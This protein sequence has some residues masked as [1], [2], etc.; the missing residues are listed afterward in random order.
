MTSGDT[1]SDV[2]AILAPAG[3]V[4]VSGRITDAAGSGIA[5]VSVYDSSNNSKT[6]GYG[7][8]DSNDDYTVN[9]LPAG[10]YKITFSTWET[11]DANSNSYLGEWYNDK[12]SFE[13]ADSVTVTVGDTTSNV[14]AI[15]AISGSISGKVTNEAGN[16]IADVYVYAHD[17][18]YSRIFFGV[19]NSTGNYTVKGC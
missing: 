5:H 1:T 4:S 2:N 19:T 6:L 18:S 13:T 7:S 14:N 8:T 16:G 12:Q 10:S 17:N 3:S 9:G 11:I 15:L